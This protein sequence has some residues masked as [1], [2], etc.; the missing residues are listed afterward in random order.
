MDTSKDLW[1]ISSFATDY[2]LNLKVLHRSIDSANAD[3]PD[4]PPRR[5]TSSL[6]VE[7]FFL[8][9]TE[10]TMFTHM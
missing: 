2:L 5:P 7:V 6:P 8:E 9:W 3:S 1:L 4:V 10:S